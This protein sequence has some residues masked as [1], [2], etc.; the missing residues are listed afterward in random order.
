[1]TNFGRINVA[2]VLPLE[3]FNKENFLD[4]AL[5]FHLINMYTKCLDKEDR[6]SPINKVII[7]LEY[8]QLYKSNEMIS[9]TLVNLFLFNIEDSVLEALANNPSIKAHP[10]FKK[11]VE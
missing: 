11:I 8:I 2:N 1:M 6:P 3:P 4:D 5:K 9:D 7:I 10:I